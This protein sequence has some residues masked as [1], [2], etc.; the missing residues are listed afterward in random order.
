MIS[1]LDASS[2]HL[3]GSLAVSWISAG[4]MPLTVI[5]LS[6]RLHLAIGLGRVVQTSKTL[7]LI[8]EY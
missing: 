6:N 1:L 5:P 8:S 2:S 7:Y 3:P 4:A